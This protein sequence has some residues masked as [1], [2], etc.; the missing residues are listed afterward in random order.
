MIVS[1]STNTSDQLER[2]NP[3]ALSITLFIRLLQLPIDKHVRNPSSKVDKSHFNVKGRSSLSNVNS[4]R[5]WSDHCNHQGAHSGWTSIYWNQST[6]ETSKYLKAECQNRYV[7]TNCST[8]VELINSRTW[9]F[10]SSAELSLKAAGLGHTLHEVLHMEDDV[11]QGQR[12][13]QWL[14][15]SRSCQFQDQAIFSKLRLPQF[16]SAPRT[17]VTCILQLNT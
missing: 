6:W 11:P 4:A 5:D 10:T 15:R 7:L 12:R 8:T 13:A 14:D 9:A 2:E 16:V 17:Y 3:R 1:Y